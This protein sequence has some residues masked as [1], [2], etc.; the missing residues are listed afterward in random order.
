M[1][2]VMGGEF[3]ILPAYLKPNKQE[4]GRIR[5]A[6]GRG[7]LYSILAQ[8]NDKDKSILLPD[9]LC[10]S[11]TRT[12]TDAG[13]K[14]EFYHI[15]KALQICLPREDILHPFSAIL[16]INYFVMVDAYLVVE[17]IRKS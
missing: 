17:P 12:V 16:L 13:W 2:E 1:Q 15:D 3:P 5:Y 10:D 7:A 14:Y 6:S 8:L 9:Y 11:V 4:N